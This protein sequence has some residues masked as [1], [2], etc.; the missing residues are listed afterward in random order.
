MELEHTISKYSEANVFLKKVMDQK[1]EMLQQ[2]IKGMLI[3]K[4]KLLY[5]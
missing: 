3:L 5:I 4:S 1:E 2:F